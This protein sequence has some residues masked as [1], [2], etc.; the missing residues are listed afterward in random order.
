M[1]QDHINALK[2]GSVV[3]EFRIERM[4]GHGG[5]GITYLA[6]DLHLNNL[7]AM[8][9]Y[10]PQEFAVRAANSTI[11]PKSTNDEQG[12]SWGLDRFKQEARALARFKH[13]NIVRCARLIEANNTAYM[14]MDYEQGMALSD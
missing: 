4:L 2:A 12:Y 6:R 13:P 9:E 11:V 3:E 14:V 10:L 8:K 7:V 1:A 5:F